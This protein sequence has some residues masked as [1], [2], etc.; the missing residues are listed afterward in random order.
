MVHLS[1]MW[2]LFDQKEHGDYFCAGTTDGD[3]FYSV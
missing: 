1:Q 2:G 3:G